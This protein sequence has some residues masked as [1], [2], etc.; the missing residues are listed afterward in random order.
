MFKHTYTSISERYLLNEKIQCYLL[1]GIDNLMKRIELSLLY[2][3]YPNI[4]EEKKIDLELNNFKELREALAGDLIKE[5]IRRLNI[6][7]EEKE[8]ILNL[9]QIESKMLLITLYEYYLREEMVEYVDFLD[10]DKEKNVKGEKIGENFKTFINNYKDEKY[11]E[12]FDIKVKKMFK[13]REAIKKIYIN[14]PTYFLLYRIRNNLL[15][16]INKT[17]CSENFIKN[18]IKQIKRFY[19]E[20]YIDEYNK[21]FFFT[22]KKFD[23]MKNEIFNHIEEEFLDWIRNG[24]TVNAGNELVVKFK[25][26]IQKDIEYNKLKNEY[27]NLI[28]IE[29]GYEATKE[30]YEKLQ[31]KYNKIAFKYL[32]AKTKINANW[33]KND[34]NIFFS[35]CTVEYIVDSLSEDRI[36]NIDNCKIKEVEN[37]TIEYIKTKIIKKEIYNVFIKIENVDLQ[38][39]NVMKVSNLTFIKGKELKINID[40]YLQTECTKFEQDFFKLD[41][42]QENDVYVKVEKIEAYK[43]DSEFICNIAFKEINDIVNLIYF[44]TARDK[45]K[46]YKLGNQLLIIE[47]SNNNKLVKYL[48]REGIFDIP[49]VSNEWMNNIFTGYGKNVKLIIEAI[50]E[51]NKII[52]ENT[53]DIELLIKSNK[54]LLNENDVYNLSRDMAILIAGTNIFRYTVSYLDLRFWLIEDYIEFFSEELPNDQ[55]IQERFLNFYKRVINIIF[56]YSDLKR[57]NLIKDLQNWILKIFPDDYIY[58]EDRSNNE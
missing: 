47:N 3:S 41:K 52:N 17:K 15:R 7:M 56:S 5:R 37:E 27:I 30:K 13:D 18:S 48:T 58:K 55:F 4:D 14:R 36:Q 24:K 49:L 51:F 20:K 38:Q 54:K 29:D 34:L 11:L 46:R 12:D 16:E 28:K 33:I 22:I 2:N 45:S 19:T 32:D 44:Y 23:E 50:N 42:I 40:K 6:V 9:D 53:L 10:F 43:S 39:Q 31:E 21:K 57:N 25:N 35:Y 26:A 8:N 1:D